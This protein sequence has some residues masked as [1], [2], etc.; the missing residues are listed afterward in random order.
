MPGIEQVNIKQVKATRESAKKAAKI[1][2]KRDTKM[3]IKAQK[4]VLNKDQAPPRMPEYEPQEW[5]M[6]PSLLLVEGVC[7][8]A[9]SSLPVEYDRIKR[10]LLSSQDVAYLLDRNF[11]GYQ[12][13]NPRLQLLLT[14]GFH[15]LQEVISGAGQV[16]QKEPETATQS[17]P[18][19]DPSLAFQDHEPIQPKTQCPPELPP[20]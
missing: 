9:S 18:Q 14:L 19:Q 6:A 8:G 2:E 20:K 1:E 7:Q 3:K 16:K 12:I 11:E 4:T 15:V 5:K 10:R 17:L 13:E